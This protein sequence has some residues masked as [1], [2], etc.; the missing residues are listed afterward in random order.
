M[1]RKKETGFCCHHCWTFYDRDDDRIKDLEPIVE[2]VKST[3]GCEDVFYIICP[4]CGNPA[5]EAG[6]NMRGIAKINRE[7]LQTGPVT[8][9]GKAKV[10]ALCKK[11]ANGPVT[12]EGKRR[13]SKNGFK[14]GR[15]AK[16]A[17]ELAPC[18][19]DR[20][21]YCSECPQEVRDKCK[22]GKLKWCPTY[23]AE[24]LK[25]YSSFVSGDLE[26]L[27]NQAALNHAKLSMAQKMAFKELFESGI[28]VFDTVKKVDANGDETHTF[29]KESSKMNPA[30]EFIFKAMDILGQ[31]SDQQT[32]NPK[33]QKEDSQADGFLKAA[34]SLADANQKLTERRGIVSKIVEDL[35]KISIKSDKDKE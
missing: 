15:F 22:A 6:L 1:Y 13:V 27:S 28:V 5:A 16:T 35:G 24:M 32:M 7:K 9:E 29:E 30:A 20:L 19:F 2:K 17:V 3:D 25:Y 14:H 11:Y 34:E 31:T 12:E 4:Q 23:I 33:T 10:A 8:P 18:K 26:A 21:P